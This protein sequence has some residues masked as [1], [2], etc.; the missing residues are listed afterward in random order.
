MNADGTNQREFYGGSSFFPTTILHAR[1]IPGG[2]RVVAIATG[3]H[4]RQTGKL[5]ELDPSPGCQEDIGAQLIA[6]LR[7]TPAERIDAYGQSGELFQ[8]PYP[9][10]DAEYLVAYH[11]AGW[12]WAHG[13]WGPLFGVY[14]MD[15]DGRRELLLNDPA[16]PCG[17]PIPLV[18][19]PEPREYPSQ[20]D[21]R[22]PSATCYIQDVYAGSGCDAVPRGT[23][24]RLRVVTLDFRA[25]GI[26]SNRNRGPGGSALISTPVAIGNG[27]WDSKRIV[28]ETE[29]HADGSAYFRVPA[30]LPVYFQLLDD[31]GQLVQTMRSW[32]TLQ[33]GENASCVGCHEHKNSVPLAH[34]VLSEALRAGP[35]NLEPLHTLHGGFSFPRYVQ[36]ILDRHCVR[37][38]NGEQQVPYDLTDTPVADPWAKRRWSRA[39]LEL[40]HARRDEQR[41]PHDWRGDADHPLVNW[42]SAQSAPSVLA[43]FSAG[44]T[45]S[46]L[47]PLLAAQHA[48]AVLSPA[49]LDTI[50]AWIDLGVPFCGDYEEAHDWNDQER[51]FYRRFLTK[52]RQYEDEERRSTNSRVGQSG[53]SHE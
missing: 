18:P 16:M 52:R 23:V 36:P 47:L 35:A 10:S 29:V 51:D 37:C 42:V 34:Q 24:R 48:G 9:V 40:T 6:P 26:G 25:A 5:I 3:H 46:R 32:T 19:R 8:Y 4:S 33:P 31:Q 39:Y 53:G 30:R 2:N 44:S 45:R 14:W 50:A 27:T 20:V 7:D 12:P 1:A 17:Q 38:H 11:P 49:E 15:R 13:P 43:P 21:Y 41:E 28:G 22:Q